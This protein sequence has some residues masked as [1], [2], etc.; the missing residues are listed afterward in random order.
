MLLLC[1]IELP[2]HMQA[3]HFYTRFAKRRVSVP[4]REKRLDMLS[5]WD[6]P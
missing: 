5:R 2:A 4:H 6:N 3:A 1:P